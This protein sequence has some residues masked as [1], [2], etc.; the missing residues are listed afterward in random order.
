[1][2]NN[3]RKIEQA[4]AGQ[5]PQWL[6][7]AII[8]IV[9]ALLPF[10]YGKY[11][12]LNSKDAFDSALN[13]FHS[14]ELL[15]GKKIFDEV[16]P[17][18]RPGTLLVNTIGVMIFGYSE[19]GPKLIQMVMQIG[20]LAMAF[21][22]IRKLY[23]NTAAGVATI[24]GAFYLS[25]QPYAKFGNV[26]EQYMIACMLVAGC[27]FI[28]YQFSNR[29]F[30][31]R[32]A[33]GFAI[34]TWY[35]KPTGFSIAAAI[36]IYLIV[37]VILRRT[38][39]KETGKII[40][41][42][43][44]GAAIG[45][46]PVGLFFAILGEPTYISGSF[47]GSVVVL[48]IA[49][50]LL[51]R[52][53]FGL[54]KKSTR[55]V[56]DIDLRVQLAA[57][58]IV[59]ISLIASYFFYVKMGQTGYFI[60]DMPFYH[61]IVAMFS[62]MGGLFNNSFGNL[63]NIFFSDSGYVAGSHS[64]SNFS[65]QLTEV[66][67]YSHSFV[68][69]IG[70]GLCAILYQLAMVVLQKTGR[71]KTDSSERN[72]ADSIFLLLALWWLFDMLFIWISPRAYVQ[73]F[74][75]PNASAMFLAGY[76]IGKINKPALALTAVCWLTVE[77]TTTGTSQADIDKFVL[78]VSILAIVV[79]IV[80]FVIKLENKHVK[81]FGIGTVALAVILSNI[82][83]CRAMGEKMAVTRSITANQGALWEH[84]GRYIK[85]NSSEED[86]IYVWGW[87]PGIYVAAQRSAPT[88]IAA[89]SDMHSD[90]PKEVGRIV[91]STVSELRKN[92][93]LYIVD[94]QKMHYPFYDHPVYD[95]WPTLPLGLGNETDRKFLTNQE[96][97]NYYLDNYYS[98]LE[99]ACIS[100]VTQPKRSGGPLTAEKA[101][102]LAE[103]EVA[104]H[105]EIAPLRKFVIENYSP[106]RLGNMVLLQRKK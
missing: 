70:F 28:N 93:P 85:E 33:G 48:V 49:G 105:R 44:I 57:I 84:I 47:P 38:S 41:E 42:L 35:F 14:N 11:Y 58:A 75:P 1:M 17:A 64:V 102:E 74:L 95:L 29:V 91:R 50:Y 71:V 43:F 46:M 92:M 12:E 60:K 73:Y 18:A 79:A 96:E 68:I 32:M 30:W 45:L 5:I 87:Y 21:A 27:S 63:Y 53:G 2:K 97:I 66:M 52:Y 81:I 94:S 62:S 8:T 31:L 101:Q 22:C 77:L 86:T 16:R 26:K 99:K 25:S 24:L 20:A 82:N 90:I 100:L 23:G 34:N 54:L 40:L 3:Q 72:P 78:G 7:P 89:Y 51:V 106:R 76:I 6:L 9:I 56:K 37:Q 104:R 88:R 59:A 61:P 80:L 67:R 69:P 36:F 15:Q 19:L 103:L 55:R 98:F 39:I 10:A 65:R 83:N 13:I 4:K